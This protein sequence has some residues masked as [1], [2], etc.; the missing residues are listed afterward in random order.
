MWERGIA[1]GESCELTDL[2]IRLYFLRTP[3]AVVDSPFC[4]LTTPPIGF[5][6]VYQ[7]FEW[8]GSKKIIGV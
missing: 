2:S 6:L 5:L 8:Y 1:Q 7:E 3:I 4:F